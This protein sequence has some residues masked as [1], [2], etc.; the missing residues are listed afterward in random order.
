MLI[1]ILVTAKWPNRKQAWIVHAQRRELYI[2]LF[3]A[4]VNIGG[5]RIQRTRA[6]S[7]NSYF[8]KYEQER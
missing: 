5:I 7:S 2:C 1:W 6:K 3:S 4:I 8:N